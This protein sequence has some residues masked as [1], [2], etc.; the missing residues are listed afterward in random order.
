MYLGLP[1]EPANGHDLTEVPRDLEQTFSAVRTALYT[2]VQTTAQLG[3][4]MASADVTP[5]Q[6]LDEFRKQDAG[7]DLDR[8][9]KQLVPNVAG[10]QAG[11]DQAPRGAAPTWIRPC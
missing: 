9:L 3:L 8:L 6:F 1:P 4:P 5:K 7:G 10:R 2:L 11:R